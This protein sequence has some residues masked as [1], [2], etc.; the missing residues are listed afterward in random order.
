MDTKVA[1]EPAVRQFIEEN[2]MFRLDRTTLSET[3]SLLEAGL[4]DSTGVL[5]LVN[6]IETKFQIKMA[7]ADIVPEKLDSIKAI[8]QYVQSQTHEGNGA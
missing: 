8:V 6:F 3:E 1:I 7:D 2:F 4:I 5:E